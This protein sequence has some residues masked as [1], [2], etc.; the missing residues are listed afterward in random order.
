MSTLR[1]LWEII[2]VISELIKTLPT[3]LISSLL[4]GKENKIGYKFMISFRET[5]FVIY[6][7]V[8][9]VRRGGGWVGCNV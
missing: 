1:L 3:N 5:P 8:M 6:L 7:L 2:G 4:F 9:C